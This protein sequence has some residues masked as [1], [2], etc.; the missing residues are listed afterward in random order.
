[1]S[2]QA[3]R[4]LT[5]ALHAVVLTGVV[6]P[7]TVALTFVDE[8]RV[9]PTVRWWAR[10]LLSFAGVRT[11][12]RGFERLPEGNFVLVC[13]HLSNF[14]PVVVLAFVERHLRFVAKAELRRVPLLG[15]AM[16]IAGNV[17]VDRRGGPKD[18]E[19]MERAVATVRE[20]TSLCFFGEGTRSRDGSLRAFKKGA[21]IMAIEAQVPLVPAAI[22]GTH[23][24]LPPGRFR[25]RPGTVGLLV[26]TPISTTGLTVEARGELTAQAR[27]QVAALLDEGE[28]VVSSS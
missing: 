25:I 6:S 17:Y 27:A 12:V 18:R 11:E 10:R 9:D 23:R 13:N 19:L 22:V 8:R 20:R 21:A 4:E 15:S 16:A 2:L 26:G 3:L 28:R 1:M 14:D 7:L 24:V 5:S